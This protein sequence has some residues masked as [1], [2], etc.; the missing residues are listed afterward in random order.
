MKSGILISKKQALCYF[1]FSVVMIIVVGL[2]AGLSGRA[3]CSDGH[4]VLV[5]GN[6]NGYENG[7]HSKIKDNSAHS[8]DEVVNTKNKGQEVITLEEFLNTTAKELGLLTK[9]QST[10]PE[11]ST[12]SIKENDKTTTTKVNTTVKLESETTQKMTVANTESQEGVKTSTVAN[13]T[14]GVTQG[15]IET[16]VDTHY[17][18]SNN[19]GDNDT[20]VETTMEYMTIANT[21]VDDVETTAESVHLQRETTVGPI[22]STTEGMSHALTSTQPPSL[23]TAEYGRKGPWLDTF[24]PDNLIPVH[25]DLWVYPD[26]YHDG[27]TFAGAVNISIN[28]TQV[29][30]YLLV[31]ILD[32]NISNTQVWKT[33]GSL[34]DIKQTFAYETNHYWVVDLIKPVYAGS[35]LTLHLKFTGSL[36]NEGKQGFFKGSYKNTLTGQQSWFVTSMF[37]PAYARR[38]FP[39]FD[40]P[41]YRSTFTIRTQHWSNFTAISNMPTQKEVI[42]DADFTETYFEKTPRMST[43]LVSYVISDFEHREKDLYSGTPH[44]VWASPDQIY[45]LDYALAL[46]QQVGDWLEDELDISYHMPKIDQIAFPGYPMATEQWGLLSYP[47]HMLAQGDPFH[48]PEQHK[49]TVTMLISH[50][51]THNYFGNL[52]TCHWWNDMWLHEGFA[53]FYQYKALQ[54]LVA[55]WNPLEYIAVRT[56]QD[57][58]RLDSRDISHPLESHIANSHDAQE[59]IFDQIPYNK[60]AAIL[61]MLEEVIGPEKFKTGIQKF[62]KRN[63]FGSVVAQDLWD[64]LQE[65]VG[66]SFDVT[67]LM[68]PWTE[69]MGYPV[70]EISVPEEGKLTATASHFTTNPDSQELNLPNSHFRYQWYIPMTL[71]TPSVTKEVHWLNKTSV[72]FPDPRYSGEWIKF[73]VKQT[74]F[75]RVNYTPDMWKL[76]SDMLHSGYHETFEAIERSNLLD[77][78]FNLARASKLDY[79]V[80]LHM[81]SYLPAETHYFPWHS[82]RNAMDYISQM[83]R[84]T[85]QYGLWMKY[86]KAVTIKALKVLRV[87]D[88]GDHLQMLLRVDI[89]SLAC[90][91]GSP[92]AL[93]YVAQMFRHWLHD[94]LHIPVPATIRHIVYGVG[95]QNDDTERTWDTLWRRYVN[96]TSMHEKNSLL[97]ALAQ[98]KQLWLIQRYLEY[99]W[100]STKGHASDF[101]KSMEYLSSNP[102]ASSHLWDWTREHYE[103]INDRFNSNNNNNNNMDKMISNIASTFNRQFLLN[104]VQDFFSKH[105]HRGLTSNSKYREEI[106]W[107]IKTNIE[108]MKRNKDSVIHYLKTDLVVK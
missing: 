54:Y 40:E 43:Y 105:P 14:M 84:G 35:S 12:M 66:S 20:N 49:D 53:T 82:A 72:T 23:S 11:G 97:D 50:Q 42:L 95:L 67:R 88:T 70:V 19:T 7:H 96:S 27:S 60:G 52:I 74:G 63:K 25:Y 89:L 32:L 57:A 3:R 55:E 6:G 1:V 59:Q 76:I 103:E 48:E 86:V 18:T 80:V 64:V 77:D 104:E 93:A 81:A 108:W 15:T 30:S 61:R 69:Q 79:R 65:E 5:N 107:N 16:T 75:Y 44:K 51:L 71:M 28:I 87:E 83:L 91:A 106:L 68:R 4:T 39:C 34:I 21:V 85:P 22:T 101:F 46:G 92:V 58:M 94:S 102:I 29:T 78:A 90:G 36:I 31:H 98:T 45:N 100:D 38:A 37:K 56:V 47:L 2:M 62:L 26:F 73:N 33:N 9:K 17:I 41:R 24:L 10:S 99:C 8:I 13:Q